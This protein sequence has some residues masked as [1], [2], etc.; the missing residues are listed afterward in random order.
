MLRCKITPYEGTEPYVFISYAHKDS[1]LVFPIL[2]ELDRRGYR[3]WYD[4]GIAPGSEWPENIAQHLNGCSLTIAFLSPNSIVSDN[5]RREVNFALS[6]QKAFLGIMLQPTEMS[7]GMEMQLS[8]QQCVVRHT[9]VSEEAFLNKVCSCPDLLPCRKT[10]HTDTPVPAAPVSKTVSSGKR[11]L[12]PWIIGGCAALAA[13]AAVLAFTL[14][15]PK[16]QPD[17]PENPAITEPQS[18]SASME[19]PRQIILHGDDMTEEEY[20]ASIQLLEERLN[21]FTGGRY[22]ITTKD[23]QATIEVPHS[24]FFDKEEAYV[25][26]AYLSRP[27]ELYLYHTESTG[28]GLPDFIQVKRS[29]LEAVTLHEGHLPG[30]DVS[31][32]GIE[33][34]N[35]KYFQITL[36]EDFAAENKAQLALWGKNIAF[37]QDLETAFDSG[38][39]YSHFTYAS[40]DSRNLYI[41][42][43]DTEGPFSDLFLYNLTHDPLPVPFTFRV[44]DLFEWENP[45]ES[46]TP[47]TK[48]VTEPE[49]IDNQVTLVYDYYDSDADLPELLKLE[50]AM[51]ARFDAL[52][53]P[54]AY[55]KK[56]NQPASFVF[57]TSAEHINEELAQVLGVSAGAPKLSSD[58]CQ[59]CSLGQYQLK[60]VEQKNGT[61]ALHLQVPEDDWY[62]TADILEEMT[63]FLTE[64]GSSKLYL[65]IDDMRFASTEITEPITD[66]F[67]LFTNC[68]LADL[69]TIDADHSYLYNLIP[70][71]AD[72]L[73]HNMYQL[74]L[75]Y[76]SFDADSPMMYGLPA[77]SAAK[78]LQTIQSA[79]LAIAPDATV[80]RNENTVYVQ[81]S[82]PVDEQLPENGLALVQQVY[83]AAN[84]KESTFSSLLVAMIKEDD[85]AGERCR[86]SFH[87]SYSTLY[88]VPEEPMTDG[89]IDVSLILQGERMEPYR[90]VFQSILETGT[91]FSGLNVKMD[92]AWS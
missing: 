6:K 25:L 88:E 31:E 41:I 59:L 21:I 74:E 45:A 87:K 46:D 90:E 75:S 32:L 85:A 8:S 84:L 68:H 26:R 65:T 23:Q 30:V 15:R 72:N 17:V 48:Q 70:V 10:E 50:L 92:D 77:S 44:I 28:L 89:T 43:N 83:E 67:L 4:D 79:I 38:V 76:V 1:H 19:K 51:K 80:Y 33:T 69:D 86:V 40:E 60:V 2:E 13:V 63:G 81:L 14:S 9:F 62:H 37:G 29:D 34:E 16:S 5:C 66:G 7:L 24:A 18:D 3:I 27:I 35:Y 82:V 22:T 55:G 20:A 54:Y 12:L 78:E 71:L 49:L 53:F 52:G 58:L 91:Y 47:G 61:Y 42:N 39:V 64:N 57:K 36:T 11:R 56:A 73:D